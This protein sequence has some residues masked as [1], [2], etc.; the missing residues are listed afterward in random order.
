MPDEVSR[1]IAAL[2]SG[3]PAYFIQGQAGQS[4][5]S[6]HRHFFTQSIFRNAAYAFLPTFLQSFLQSFLPT[7]VPG[8]A[9]P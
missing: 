2:P 4:D 6:F 7:F 1:Q 9:K 5:D 8:V 3:K